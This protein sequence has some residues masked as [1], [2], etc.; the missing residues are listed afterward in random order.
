M[1]GKRES[2][3]STSRS[4]APVIFIGSSGLHIFFGELES[5]I[6]SALW[7]TYPKPI[8]T[9]EIAD[10]SQAGKIQSINTSLNRLREKGMV[11]RCGMRRGADQ[12]TRQYLWSTVLNES[13]TIR[14]LIAK[15]LDTFFAEYYTEY[16]E[17]LRGTPQNVPH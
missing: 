3:R 5:K 1:P 12:R 9:Q 15:T 17:A 16:Q 8:T 2:K 6:L 14:E 7:E 10:I 4:N 11:M 13:G